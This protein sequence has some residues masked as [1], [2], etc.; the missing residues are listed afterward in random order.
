MREETK[1][2]TSSSRLAT[3]LARERAGENRRVRLIGKNEAIAGPVY[4]PRL[5]KEVL[6]AFGR[7]LVDDRRTKEM[8]SEH[9]WL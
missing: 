5:V 9:D 7:Q 6:K 4:S 3:L 8:V 1:W 2:A